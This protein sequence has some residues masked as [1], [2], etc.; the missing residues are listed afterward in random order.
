LVAV[1]EVDAGFA[2]VELEESDRSALGSLG[3]AESFSQ[4][5]VDYGGEG[6]AAVGR[7]TLDFGEAAVLED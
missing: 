4:E 2:H 6:L 3:A 1:G 5:F 7:E